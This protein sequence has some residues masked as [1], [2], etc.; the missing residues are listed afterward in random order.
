MQK[1]ILAKTDNYTL[2]LE[3]VSNL[4]FVHCDVSK[5]NKTAKKEIEEN[6]SKAVNKYGVLYVL[7]NVEGTDRPSEKFLEMYKFSFY[8][9]LDCIDGIKRP[10][11]IRQKGDK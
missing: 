10:M 7:R 11:W 4:F 2:S 1:I 8:K 3:P 9:H 5:W 6:V